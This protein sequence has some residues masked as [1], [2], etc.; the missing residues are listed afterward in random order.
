MHETTKLRRR[1]E[2]RNEPVESTQHLGVTGEI[3][4]HP[5]SYAR[6]EVSDTALKMLSC[7]SIHKCSLP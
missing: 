7:S 3:I 6:G 5:K 4:N 2:G 1:K